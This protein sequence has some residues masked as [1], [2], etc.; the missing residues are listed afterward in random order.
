MENN[1]ERQRKQFMVALNVDDFEIN[2]NIDTDDSFE[3]PEKLNRELKVI[4][5]KMASQMR[6]AIKEKRSTQQEISSNIMEH[7][8][9]KV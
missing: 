9:H 5:D 7:R 2:R 8:G 3:M 6:V 4:H 1:G